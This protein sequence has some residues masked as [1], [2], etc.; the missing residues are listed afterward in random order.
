[1]SSLQR[2]RILEQ[3]GRWVFHGSSSK[4]EVLEPRQAYQYPHNS[5]IG[6]IRDD[7]PAIFTSPVADIAIFMAIINK[8]NAPKGSRS[9]FYPQSDGT[10]TFR[11]TKETMEQIKNARG[12]VY[13]FSKEK[14]SPRS[15]IEY[16]SYG[17]IR[18]EEVLSVTEE[19]LPVQIE[20][21]EF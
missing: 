8:T 13:V 14:F 18:P 4:L 2:L 1:M 12:Y 16:V 7:R 9:G 10:V 6:K 17:S 11:A 15:N 20:I 19:D 21:Q 5:D 3:E